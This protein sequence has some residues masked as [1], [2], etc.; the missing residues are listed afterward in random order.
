MHLVNDLA[1]IQEMLISISEYL[2]VAKGA[3]DINDFEV[4]HEML[5]QVNAL[6]EL[7]NRKVDI[8]VDV[9][10]LLSVKLNC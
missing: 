6:I 7:A 4:S 10:D 1:D 5:N 9:D 2:S 8:F 3:I